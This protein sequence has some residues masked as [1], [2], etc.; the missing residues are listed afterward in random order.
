MP[1]VQAHADDEAADEDDGEALASVVLIE[2]TLAPQSHLDQTHEHLEGR[3][4]QQVD[5]E[6]ELVQIFTPYR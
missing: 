6:A 1:F 5:D 4:A 3:A 2:R